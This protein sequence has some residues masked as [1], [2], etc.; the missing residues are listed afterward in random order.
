[1]PNNFCE[2]KDITCRHCR[3]WAE[4]PCCPRLRRGRARRCCEAQRRGRAAPRGGNIEVLFPH[5]FH[6]LLVDIHLLLRRN[7]PLEHVDL[8][9]LDVGRVEV[10][11]ERLRQR[12]DDAL[13][14]VKVALAAVNIRLL[15]QIRSVNTDNNTHVRL[16]VF[17]CANCRTGISIWR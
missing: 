2:I 1:M 10:A 3:R 8:V 9:L 14:L 4:R 15:A 17:I 16:Q 7:G 13:A 11:L 12:H 6:H 5:R